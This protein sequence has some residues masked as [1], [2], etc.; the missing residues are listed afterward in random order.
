MKS[1]RPIS[2]AGA[3]GAKAPDR[4][5]DCTHV[6]RLFSRLGD[7]YRRELEAHRE[8]LPADNRPVRYVKSRWDW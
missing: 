8:I 3:K 2:K 6:I 4:G 5:S 1:D 7:S